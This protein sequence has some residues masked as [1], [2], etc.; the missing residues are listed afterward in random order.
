M[1]DSV[2]QTDKSGDKRMSFESMAVYRVLRF[3]RDFKYGR[4]Q[5]QRWRV[6][7]NSHLY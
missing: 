7:G 1:V 4:C 3:D 5:G 2:E 6:L